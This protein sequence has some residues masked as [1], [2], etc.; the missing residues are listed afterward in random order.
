[1]ADSMDLVQQRVEEDRLR[2]IHK[3]RRSN[4]AVSSFIC[5][6]CGTAIPEARRI[7]VQGVDTCVT[8]QEVLELKSQHYKGAL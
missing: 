4:A 6:S 8:C 1:M 2:Y 7:A 5:E 3:A